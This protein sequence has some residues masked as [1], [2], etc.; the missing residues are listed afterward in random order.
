MPDKLFSEFTPNS[1]AEWQEKTIKDLK[2]KPFEDLFLHTSDNILL[3]P[4]YLPDNLKN[5]ISEQPVS[6]NEGWVV[7]YACGPC[8]QA[9]MHACISFLCGCVIDVVWGGRVECAEPGTVW[10]YN[11]FHL[12][13]AGAMAKRIVNYVQEGEEVE[14]G[15][16][17]GFIKFGSRVDLFLPLDAK[18]EVSLGQKVKGNRTVIARF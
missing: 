14:Q 5:Q 12:Q 1:Y 6:D 4:L 7:V 18:L 11:S 13:I 2:G 9:C 3:N 15:E 8:M 16:D 10:A 17:M